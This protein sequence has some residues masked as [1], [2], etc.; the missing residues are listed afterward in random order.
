MDA[1]ATTPT[2]NRTV[3]RMTRGMRVGQPSRS[4]SQTFG[5]SSGDSPRSPR[6]FASKCTMANT[7][8]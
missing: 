5:I 6:R 1:I 8:M 4:T 2:L 3:I 7:A